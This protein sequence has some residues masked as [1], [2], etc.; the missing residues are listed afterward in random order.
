MVNTS[1][2]IHTNNT[3]NDYILIP[4]YDESQEEL[5][6]EMYEEDADHIE[7]FKENNT[8]YIGACYKDVRECP[9]QTNSIIIDM[10]VSNRLF[11]KYSY[12]LICKL[13]GEEN[14]NDD[15]PYNKLYKY[16]LYYHKNKELQL[17]IFKTNYKNLD[18]HPFKWD[19]GV[20]IKT[21]WLRLVQRTWKRIYK[22]RQYIVKKRMRP[23]N[24]HYR[25]IHGHWPYGLNN[26]P[27]IWGML[28]V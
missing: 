22:E 8:Y 6:Q 3:N 26:L 18:Q 21:F 2:E 14:L 23:N 24:L 20:I 7:E 13:L 19:L 5:L 25:S 12:D 9:R 11:L 28:K 17:Q 27:G 15:E 10:S 4:E 16:W 1:Q